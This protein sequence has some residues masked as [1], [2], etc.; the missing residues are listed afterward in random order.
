M[1]DINTIQ[2]DLKRDVHNLLSLLKFI[3]EDE[4]IK[5]PEIKTMLDMALE[6]ESTIH[7]QLNDLNDFFN[8]RLHGA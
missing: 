5:D 7:Q 3:K 8:G 4:E 6:K 1:K 2:H